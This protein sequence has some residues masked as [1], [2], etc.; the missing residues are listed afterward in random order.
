[1]NQNWKFKCRA[2]LVVVLLGFGLLAGCSGWKPS[3]DG[4]KSGSSYR[5]TPDGYY[6]VKRGD[7]L[8]AIAFKF[9]M[10]WRNIAKWNDIRSPYT[11][12]PD[13]DLRLFAPG[14]T[15]NQENTPS[16]TGSQG[17]VTA[18]APSRSSSSSTYDVP[19]DPKPAVTK[20]ETAPV[21]AGTSPAAP[22]KAP[23]QAATYSPANVGDPAKWLWPADGKIISNFAPNDPTR[24][25]I[26]IG[27]KEGQ[28]VV[29]S[30]AGEVV[31][32]GSG[33]IGYGELVIIKHN[34]RLLSAYA[35]NDKR[36]VTEGQKVA[37]GERIA[38][39]GKNDRSQAMLHFEIRLNG[40]PQD[41]LKYL[42]GR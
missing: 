18:P 11:I 24:K 31:Y 19:A 13:Q 20:A 35:H 32:S 6:R 12:Y 7:T 30:A 26:D 41:P 25:G 4:S 10:D 40:N 3:E 9:G 36:L 39:M 21:P 1:V 38:D 28:A 15:A 42:P 27:G 17:V 14:A 29:A 34:E 16:A 2:A 22:A 23:A 37:A 5:Q 8:H 33:L